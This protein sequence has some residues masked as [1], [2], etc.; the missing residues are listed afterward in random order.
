MLRTTKA[1]VTA[2]RDWRLFSKSLFR[3]KRIAF[4]LFVVGA[5]GLL[6]IRSQAAGLACPEIRPG[7]IS[8][9]L[10]DLQVKLVPS[11]DRLELT[12]EVNDLINK[13]QILK[14]NISY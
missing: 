12:N 9:L 10:G 11:A 14:P 3:W 1:E 13:L 7:Q 5:L 2:T 6:P 8:N 4:S